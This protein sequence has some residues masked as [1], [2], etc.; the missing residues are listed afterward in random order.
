MNSYAIIPP[1][2]PSRDA[3]DIENHR[4][5][6]AVAEFAEN[7]L[8]IA[9][10]FFAYTDGRLPSLMVN[11]EA[12]LAA[13][14]KLC[15]RY[16][17]E[18]PAGWN[19]ALFMKECGQR[20]NPEKIAEVCMR[21]VLDANSFASALHHLTDKD[22]PRGRY[23]LMKDSMNAIKPHV[24]ANAVVDLPEALAA[25]HEIQ[26]VDATE[27][28]KDELSGM[29]EQRRKCAT[30]VQEAQAVYDAALSHG[31]V[32]EVERA[33]RYLI[34]ARYEYLV[35]YAKRLHFLSSTEE[36]DEVVH[37]AD[38]LQKLREDAK[39]A[40]K[41]F[42]DDK[43]AL[44]SEL[45]TDLVNC[46]N[47]RAHEAAS[48][49]AAQVAF[50]EQRKK[51][52]ASLKL[53]VERK[54]QLVHELLQKAVELREVMEQQ[55]TM[56][57]DVVEAV[58]TEAERV[59]A[60]EEFVTIG[61]QHVQRLRRCLEYCDGCEPVTRAMEEYV[62]EMV[63]KLPE[64]SAENALN[65]IIDHESDEFLNVYRA[66]V[67]VCG[68]LTVKKTHRLDTLE[69]QARL[70][71][72][73]R[74]SAMDS[75]DPNY[76][77]YRE[78]LAEVLAQAQAVEGVINALHATQDAGEQVF[79]SVED[80][81]LS[82]HERTEKPF[83]HP[84]QELGH[85]S[86][87]ARTRFV[88]RSMKYVEG[89]EQEVFQKKARIAEAKALVEQEQ[90]ALERGVNAAAIAAPVAAPSSAAGDAVAAPAQIRA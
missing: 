16:R 14:E 25:L 63:T 69:R 19:E 35:C 67:F 74:D 77:H 65:A 23:L 2:Y 33:H 44:K 27:A 88:N 72:H 51:M 61:N 22:L 12:I 84:L 59:T 58:K 64:E 46:D 81:V 13:F 68:E 36:D 40:V 43:D 80:L 20:V 17:H 49:D 48:H 85:E 57:Q 30:Q 47:A 56:T 7:G 24:P 89:E 54:A 26:H 76:K 71:Q 60:H 66:F 10:N 52:D 41:V 75:L 1:V 62:K 31:D 82:S 70:A 86:I 6:A 79:E 18:R 50:K 9:D 42:S 29:D 32:I 53:I 73:N 90:E 38:R 45:Q 37:F 78:E 28:I 4:A 11:G 15:E 5:V 55:R 21:P 34:A 8:S 3:Q 39:D 87:A 83:V